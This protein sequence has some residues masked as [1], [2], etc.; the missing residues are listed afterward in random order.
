[1]LRVLEDAGELQEFLERAATTEVADAT[2]EGALTWLSELRSE[3]VGLRTRR[4][5]AAARAAPSALAAGARSSAASDE[6]N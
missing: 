4:Q 6:T 1:M 5:E 2:A 3:H